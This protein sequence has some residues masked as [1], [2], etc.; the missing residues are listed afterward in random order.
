MGD[1]ILWHCRTAVEVIPMRPDLPKC[2]GC[3][4]GFHSRHLKE[5]VPCKKL[6][7]EECSVQH[8]CVTDDTPIQTLP[9]LPAYRRCECC[10]LQKK[11]ARCKDCGV[12]YCEWCL[13]WHECFP[14]TP[15]SVQVVMYDHDTGD[16]DRRE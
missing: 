6:Y 1:F 2:E 11:M 14:G 10:L 8:F 16:E 5:C 7:C 9:P 15:I 13:T 4:D 3:G 12:V